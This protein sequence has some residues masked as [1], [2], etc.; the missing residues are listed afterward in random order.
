MIYFIT[1]PVGQKFTYTQLVLCVCNWVRFVRPPC[2]CTIFQFC[3][4]IFYRIEVRSLWWPLQYLDFVVLKPF[5]HNFG[6]MLGVIVHL[7]NPF[8]T[9]LPDWC[10]EMLLQ[11]PHHFRSSWCHL[12]CEVH[13]CSCSKAPPQHDAAPPVLHGWDG[14]HPTK[15]TR[16]RPSNVQKWAGIS[17]NIRDQLL[18]WFTFLFFPFG[19]CFLLS[20]LFWEEGIQAVGVRL[21]GGWP[22]LSDKPIIQLSFLLFASSWDETVGY[23]MT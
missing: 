2:S 23:V 19:F 14:V 18:R 3:Q 1:S 16:A 20:L 17:S 13:H 21:D 22:V 7:E 15:V 6:I 5:Y 10:L 8:A 12:F 4:Q 9:K 11:Y